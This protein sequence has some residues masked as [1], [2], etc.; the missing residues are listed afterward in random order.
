MQQA[1]VATPAEPLPLEEPAA[2]PVHPSLSPS[3]AGDFM[4]CPLLYRFRV[5]DRLPERPSAVATRG[6]VVHA[7][8]ERLF[9]LPAAERTHARDSVVEGADW[10]W[11]PHVDEQRASIAFRSGE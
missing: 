5:I 2:A 3:R 10:L 6:T 8:L 11:G 9:E 1:S 4:A 7:V